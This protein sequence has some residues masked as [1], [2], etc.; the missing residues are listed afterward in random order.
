MAIL[1]LVVLVVRGLSQSVEQHIIVAMEAG[2]SGKPAG[3]RWHW[4]I[5]AV[6]GCALLAPLLSDRT[7]ASDWGNHLWLIWVQG[8]D[9]GSLGEPS[10]FLQSSLGAFYPNYAFYGGSL[11]AALGFVSQL[12]TPVVAVALAFAGSL[13]ASYLG[14][15]WIAW[16]AGVRG[17]RSQ[18]PGCIAVTAPYAVTN[19]YGRGDIPEMVATAAIPL[20]AAAALSLIRERGRVRLPVAAAYV[21]GVA[22]LTGAHTLTLVWG[23]TFLLLLAALLLACNWRTARERAGRLRTVFWLTLLGVAINAWILVPIVLY[24]KRLAQGGPDPI[25]ATAY[26]DPRRLFSLFRD[27]GEPYPGVTGDLNTQLPVLAL[28]WTLVFGAAFRRFFSPAG[29]RLALGLL[30]IFAAFLLLILAPSL[31]AKLPEALRYIQFPYRLLTFT[32][33]ALVGLIVLVLAAL[34]RAG[35]Q[36]RIP[37]LLLA[38]IALLNLGLSIDQN[39]QVRSWLSGRDQALASPVRPPP[40]W[41]APLQ[42]ADAS[43][44]VVTPTLAAPLEV[45]VKSGVDSYTVTYPAG[46]AGSAETNIL[47]GPYLVGLSGA[48]PVGRTPEGAMVVGL[49]ASR[50]PRRVTVKPAWGAAVTIGRWLSLAALLAALAAA[51]VCFVNAPG[52]ADG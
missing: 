9:I 4:L 1:D 43:A 14:W 22:V 16:Q 52:R 11:Y 38:G 6:V 32:D 8:L 51:A 42:F 39:S 48:E 36:A 20:I 13:A 10:Y 34:Q 25:T 37:V 15:T 45:P 18:L 41:Y 47:A 44:P 26:T 50:E 23:T 12:S 21:V 28:A 17:W 2:S 7:F 24:H 49:P 31:I 5:P 35:S 29:R 27:A 19:M 30:G 33:L 46:P 3:A 40:S